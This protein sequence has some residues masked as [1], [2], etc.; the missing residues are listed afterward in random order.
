MLFQLKVQTTLTEARQ[1]SSELKSY[2]SDLKVQMLP[3][4]TCKY[5]QDH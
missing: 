4:P 3:V 5:L 2:V 1:V